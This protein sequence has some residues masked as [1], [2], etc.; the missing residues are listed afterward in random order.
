MADV[1]QGAARRASLPLSVKRQQEKLAV[2]AAVV[3]MKRPAATHSSVA[4][5]RRRTPH[6]LH[7]KDSL[8]RGGVR[9]ST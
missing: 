3:R 4:K 7:R 1:V 6:T 8:R 5:K 2:K 9:S